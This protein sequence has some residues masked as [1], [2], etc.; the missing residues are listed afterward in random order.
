[1]TGKRG[2]DRDNRLETYYRVRRLGD[3]NIFDDSLLGVESDLFEDLGIEYDTSGVQRF[4]RFT[5]DA[6]QRCV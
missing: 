6:P 5:R 2:G 4:V 3:I 1:M